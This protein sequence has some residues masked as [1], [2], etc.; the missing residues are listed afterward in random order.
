MSGTV[1]ELPK[2]E[3]HGMRYTGFTEPLSI[4]MTTL[5][6][7]LMKRIHFD[8][9]DRN[10]TWAHP[11]ADTSKSA[12]LESTDLQLTRTNSRIRAFTHRTHSAASKKMPHGRIDSSLTITPVNAMAS[13]SNDVVVEGKSTNQKALEPTRG[14]SSADSGVDIG[15]N[16]IEKFND[17]DG[18]SVL[19]AKKKKGFLGK[20][21]KARP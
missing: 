10:T 14:I 13:M 2:S 17:G 6:C 1:Q 15:K 12:C 5:T 19:S 4:G 20:L 21:Q 11:D 18:D 7:H 8:L 16:S 3:Q 9:S